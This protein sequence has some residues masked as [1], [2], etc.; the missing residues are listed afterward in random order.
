MNWRRHEVNW[1]R[2]EVN[3]RAQGSRKRSGA[4]SPKTA[5]AQCGLGS[6]SWGFKFSSMIMSRLSLIMQGV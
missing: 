4:L 1:R 6:D 2:H 5:G 3:W